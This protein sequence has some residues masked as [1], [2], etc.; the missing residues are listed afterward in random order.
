MPTRLRSDNGKNFV[1]VNNEGKGSTKSSAENAYKVN[2]PREVS[3]GFSI[4]HSIPQKEENRSARFSASRG[5]FVKEVA[6]KE[7]TLNCFLIEAG[8]VK[9]HVR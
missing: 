3:N 1:H 6:P 9:T 5:C 4:Q 7:H 8:N 2:Y